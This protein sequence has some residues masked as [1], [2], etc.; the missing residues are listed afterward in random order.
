MLVEQLFSIRD[1]APSEC[2][3]AYLITEVLFL[4]MLQVSS[5]S[6]VVCVCLCV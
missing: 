1:V 6:C 3:L 4:A 2:Q 5:P